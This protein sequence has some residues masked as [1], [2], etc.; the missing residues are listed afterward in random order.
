MKLNL[1][2]IGV[3]PDDVELGCGG[4]ILSHLQL[5]HKVGIVDLTQGELGS[6]GSGQIRLK[7]AEVAGNVLCIHARENLGLAD[8][9]FE[10]NKDSQL[11]VIR[12]IRKYQ[13]DI[14]LCNAPNDRHPDHGRAS[15]LVVDAAFLSGLSRIE[16]LDDTGKPQQHWRPKVVYHYIQ[17][18]FI[19][20]DLVVDITGHMDKK[21]ESVL[22]YRSQFYDPNSNEPDTFISSPEFLDM[23]KSRA[24]E[25]GTIIGAQ[26]GEGFVAN[27]YVGVKDLTQ[28]M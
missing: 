5:G 23:V 19:K 27:R 10:N 21:M 12:T 22:A 15:K 8:G 17:A 26:Y 7:E 24:I 16:T 18:I 1:L 6:R 3:H 13:P 4:T 9:F 2:A 25:F 28:L 11:T 20:P 14:I